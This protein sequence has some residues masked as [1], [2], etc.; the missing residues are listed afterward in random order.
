MVGTTD[1]K[2]ADH[3]HVALTYNP[4]WVMG[5]SVSCNACQ[6]VPND[7]AFSRIASERLIRSEWDRH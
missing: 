1:L 7:L 4:L 3:T 5:C 6:I 2:L